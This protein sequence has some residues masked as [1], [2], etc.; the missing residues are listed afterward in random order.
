MYS[1]LAEVRTP[2]VIFS[3]NVGNT[4]MPN[5]ALHMSIHMIMFDMLISLKSLHKH[6]CLVPVFDLEMYKLMPLRERVMFAASLHL[7]LLFD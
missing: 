5:I 4:K 6:E 1:I 7:H 2:V 3:P